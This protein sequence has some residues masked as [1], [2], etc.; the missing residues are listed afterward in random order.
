MVG[1]HGG[2]RDAGEADESYIL[3]LKQTEREK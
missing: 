1:K 3:I 2:R